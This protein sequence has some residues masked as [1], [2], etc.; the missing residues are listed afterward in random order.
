MI[1]DMRPGVYFY[2]NVRNRGAYDGDTVYLDLDRGGY[3][4]VMCLV[5]ESSHPLSYRL[6]DIDAP[7][8]RPLVTRKVATEARDFLLA[9][10]GPV[11]GTGN[12]MAQTYKS[13]GTDNFGRYL[14]HLWTPDGLSLNRLMIDS[15]HAVPYTP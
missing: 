7:E 14:V 6:L 8:L 13:P 11:G 2:A 3:D 12:V 9:Q 4:W 5:G 15:G 1:V 10:M